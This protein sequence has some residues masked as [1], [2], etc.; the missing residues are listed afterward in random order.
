MYKFRFGVL[1]LMLFAWVHAASA[2]DTDSDGIT[3]AWELRHFS[4]LVAADA[5]SDFNY[6]GKLDVTHFVD[7]SFPGAVASIAAGDNHSL[8][9]RSD[10]SIVAWGSDSHGQST[11]PAGLI[12]VAAISAS[13]GHSLALQSDGSIV[14]WGNDFSG[15][16]TVPAGLTGVVAIAA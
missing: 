10:G 7:G 1:F 6:D 3:D 9:L 13:W 16:S 14:A 5:T 11:I 15:E 2:A 4:S 12:G 8:A